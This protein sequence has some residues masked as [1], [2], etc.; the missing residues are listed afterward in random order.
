MIT[1]NFE[2]AKEIKKNSLREQRAPLLQQ[3]D[4]AFQKALEL[5]QDT[6]AIVAEKQRLRDITNLANSA[7]NL[8]DLKSISC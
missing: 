4:I 2:K 7:T 3:Q 6:S 8:E 5:G 1:I